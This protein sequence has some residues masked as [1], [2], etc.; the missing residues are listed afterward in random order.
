LAAITQE[1]KEEETDDF[2]VEETMELI[3]GQKE[4]SAFC[5]GIDLQRLGGGD[6]GLPMEEENGERMDE[7]EQVTYDVLDRFARKNF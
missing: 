3:A 7:Y 5:P 2:C 6:A 4:A 1:L